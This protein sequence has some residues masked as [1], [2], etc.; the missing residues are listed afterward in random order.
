MLSLAGNIYDQPYI[1]GLFTDVFCYPPFFTE[2]TILHTAGWTLFL[3]FITALL[4]TLSGRLIIDPLR[5]F[6]LGTIT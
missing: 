3:F 2:A 4:S 1:P 6:I 5:D